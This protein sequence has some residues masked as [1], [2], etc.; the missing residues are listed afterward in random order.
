MDELPSSEVSMIEEAQPKR[1]VTSE[2]PAGD[3]FISAPM[4][5]RLPAVSQ[6]PSIVDLLSP[7]IPDQPPVISVL[8]ELNSVLPD[9]LPVQPLMERPLMERSVHDESSIQ[10]SI[11]TDSPDQPTS[12]H[13]LNSI[14]PP[15][16][17]HLPDVPPTVQILPDAYSAPPAV[18]LIQ[19]TGDTVLHGLNSIQT[20]V[21][22]NQPGVHNVNL[23][24]P[25][26]ST[27]QGSVDS[28]RCELSSVQN[29]V[30]SIQPLVD[31]VVASGVNSMQPS[32][33][34]NESSVEKSLGFEPTVSLHP[35]EAAIS[36]S[37][38][39]ELGLAHSSVE[40]SVQDMDSHQPASPTPLSVDVVSSEDAAQCPVPR[41]L[42]TKRSFTT[43]FKLECVEHAE[44]TKNKT[45]TA[46]IFNVNRR[47]VQEW[48]SQKEKLMSVPKQQKR[49]G[50]GG[51]RQ[52]SVDTS[53]KGG[54]TEGGK[55]KAEKSLSRKSELDK[56]VLKDLSS[57]MPANVMDPTLFECIARSLSNIDQSVLPASMVKMLQEWSEL[58][59]QDGKSLSEESVAEGAMHMADVLQTRTDSSPSSQFL[60]MKATEDGNLMEPP[61]NVKTEGEGSPDLES[62][63]STSANQQWVVATESALGTKTRHESMNIKGPN[64]IS[65]VNKPV[66]GTNMTDV[67]NETLH[68]DSSINQVD[69]SNNMSSLTPENELESN[70]P[71][72]ILDA[73]IEVAQMTPVDQSTAMEASSTLTSGQ[74]PVTSVS[75]GTVGGTVKI[76]DIPSTATR[77]R[78]KKCYTLEFKLECIAHAESTSKCAAARQ[79]NVDRRRVQDWCSQK[80]KLQK[81][82]GGQHILRGARERMDM[83]VEKQL[84]AWVKQQQEAG[85]HL[86]RKMVGDEATRMYHEKGDLEFLSSIGWVAKFMV[87]NNISLVSRP[88]HLPPTEVV[89]HPTS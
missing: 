40:M 18:G 9:P 47:R 72:A 14:Q 61:M 58:T 77:P 25:S 87:R 23:T 11:T 28:N 16:Y 78:V 12:L 79:F 29:A 1:G 80:E 19:S 5:T 76:E 75:N 65:D 54:H 63:Q 4:N 57:S 15:A 55:A 51:R 53:S 2:Q 6:T 85:I 37:I 44:K 27:S 43:E 24:Q 48:C 88:S 49:L 10:P 67:V 89:A 34:C 13:D 33:S 8:H 52:V 42:R 66:I 46:R 35:E 21:D 50:G 26:V 56:E 3:T 32:A 45:K 38:S 36:D 86:T 83:D 69:E 59:S 60:V 73:L 64:G 68:M 41:M 84:A 17:G 74:Q 81:L 71:V 22:I 39:P 62:Q 70:V 7:M 82:V 31:T 30:C 20:T